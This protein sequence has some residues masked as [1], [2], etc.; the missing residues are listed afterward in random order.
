MYG[1]RERSASFARKY[2]CVIAFAAVFSSVAGYLIDPD[3]SFPAAMALFSL[4]FA[5]ALFILPLRDVCLRFALPGLFGACALFLHLRQLRHDELQ[6]AFSG[7][8]VRI[9]L[10]ARAE[11]P[12]LAPGLSFLPPKKSA[13]FRVVSYCSP[14]GGRT[15]LSGIVQVSLPPDAAA[16]TGYGDMLELEGILTHPDPAADKSL[17]S[18]REY[19]RNNGVFYLLRAS[20]ATVLEPGS[21]AFRFLLD[22]RDAMLEKL[23]AGL[24][25]PEVSM[26]APGILFGIRHGIGPEEKQMFLESGIVHILSVSGTHVALAS[27][28]FFL[29]LFFL[30][31]RPQCLLAIAFTFLYALSSGMR[32]PAFRA[33]LMF[34][35]LFGFRAFHLRTEAV[36]TLFLAALLLTLRDP[37][38]LLSAGFQF[39]FL[40][41]A[42]LLIGMDAVRRTFFLP[43]ENMLLVPSVRRTKGMIRRTV[44]SRILISSLAGCVIA[45][46]VSLPLSMLYQHVWP[47]ASI[48][49]NLLILP[50]NTLIFGVFLAG[51]ALSFIPGVVLAVS[52]ILSLLFAVMRA[53]ASMCAD[54][55]LVVPAPHPLPAILFLLIFFVF[56]SARRLRTALPAGI[57]LAVFC[58]LFYISSFVRIPS[59]LLLTDGHRAS[60]C[61]AEPSSATAVIPAVADTASAAVLSGILRT[62][63]ISRCSVLFNASESTASHQA[64]EYL[65]NKLTVLSY[66][67]TNPDLFRHP[68]PVL[69]EGSCRYT[70]MDSFR[71][72]VWESR[73]YFE[74]RMGDGRSVLCALRK[75]ENGG[76]SW[77]LKCDG[78]ILYAM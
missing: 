78:K 43:P 12:S 64:L 49:A 4:P 23:C 65:K 34:A 32:E 74:V 66:A 56:L 51:A 22:I 9:R 25:P 11:D 76:F 50:L 29:L 46:L 71:A 33:F 41:V 6:S 39:S 55:S 42:A 18:Y 7:A 70:V 53:L 20:E 15:P 44:W 68:H 62:E 14:S 24:H 13:L 21:G 2:P 8:S 10:Q 72:A 58:L 17:F 19:L 27:G 67:G 60:V 40:T 77:K 75:N 1:I 57:A 61:L 54:F 59:V 69:R 48:F 63:G 52:E 38:T 45:W 3:I 16:R 31:A 47:G 26:L 28:L 5:A 35:L 36:N 37:D 30:P 73:L